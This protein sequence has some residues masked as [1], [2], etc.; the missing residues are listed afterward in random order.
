MDNL[1]IDSFESRYPLSEDL[2]ASGA[3]G[4]VYMT[5]DGN[6]VVKIQSLSSEAV[7]EVCFLSQFSHPNIC[8]LLNFS[9]DLDKKKV[10][11][12]LPIGQPVKNSNLSVREILTDIVSGISYLNHYGVIHG[13]LKEDNLIYHEGKIKLIDLGLA[14]IADKCMFIDYE[15]RFLEG[16]AYT[17][18]YRDPEFNSSYLSCYKADMYSIATT[19][20]YLY[21]KRPKS[22][23]ERKAYISRKDFRKEGI[24]DPDVIDFLMELQKPMK[25]RK[26]VSELLD[27]PALI[28]ERLYKNLLVSPEANVTRYSTG[29]IMDNNLRLSPGFKKRRIFKISFEWLVELCASSK[30][31]VKILFSAID[32][33]MKY[34][35]RVIVY[36]TKKIQLYLIIS[37]YIAAAINDRSLSISS[38]IRTTANAYTD[39]DFVTGL[40]YFFKSGI[41]DW[42]S[43]NCYNSIRYK[44]D[45]EDYISYIT[46]KNYENLKNYN[47]PREGNEGLLYKNNL[48]FEPKKFEIEDVKPPTV[49]D[50]KEYPAYYI[51]DLTKVPTHQKPELL[52]S[53]LT[54]IDDTDFDSWR[55]TEKLQMIYY[56]SLTN[57]EVKELSPEDANKLLQVLLDNS[58]RSGSKEILFRIFNPDK[59]A[60][61]FNS[62]D[63]INIFREA[64]Y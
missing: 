13:D 55:S 50:F 17:F 28:Q 35:S 64:S 31:P 52:G 20:Y 60:L 9:L 8:P 39:Q 36:E 37:L 14:G 34:L 38:L 5:T 58:T 29:Q 1:S 11:I 61:Y 44:Q 6:S 19:I 12:A 63:D 46:D 16:I 27:H 40:H 23:I 10:Y 43:V 47:F 22:P 41:R 32:I 57:Q 51:Y 59:L 45:V 25:E 26:D 30:L 56:S 54:Y 3:Y 62:G 21:A 24:K 7:K 42:H 33:F 49:E 2:L 48:V 53:L 18:P 4:K 15:S